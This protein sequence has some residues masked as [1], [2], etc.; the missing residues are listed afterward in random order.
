MRSRPARRL[1]LAV[2]LVAG[3]AGVFWLTLWL[4]GKGDDGAG[5]A[6]VLALPVAILGSMVAF[7]A[8]RSRPES[9]GAKVRARASTLLDQVAAAEARALQQLLGD[10]GRA[11]P[12]DIGFAHTHPDAAGVR[13]RV[14]GGPETGS[15]NTVAEFYGS[16]RLGRLLVLGEPGSGKTVLTVR[17]L[18]DL[19]EK[20]RT[21]SGERFRVPVRLSLPAFSETNARQAGVRERLDAW[22]TEQLTVVYGVPRSAAEALVADGWILPIFDGLDEMDP[23]AAEPRRAVEVITA[24]NTAAGPRRWPVVVAC[25]IANYRRMAREMPLQDATAVTMEPLEVGQIVDWLSHRFPDPTQPDGT[26]TRW[27]PVLN[28]VRA[29]PSGRLAKFLSSPLNLYLAA[30]VYRDPATGPDPRE[31]RKLSEAELD[32][33]LHDRLLAAVVEHNPSPDGTRYRAEDIRI[34]LSTLANHLAWMNVHGYS[35]TDIHLHELWRTTGDPARHGRRVRL[36]GAAIAAVLPTALSALLFLRAWFFSGNSDFRNN[37]E[38]WSIAL[39]A[40]IAFIGFVFSFAATSSTRAMERIEPR[41]LITITGLRKIFWSSITWML[42]GVLGGIPAG[43]VIGL[44]LGIDELAKMATD[45][46]VLMGAIGFAIGLTFG[47]VEANTRLRTANRPSDPQ[48]QVRRTILAQSAVA[49]LTLV[50]LGGFT[51]GIVDGLFLGLTAAL[52]L[53]L[54][55][56]PT[57]RLRHELAIRYHVRRHLLPRRPENFLDWAHTAGLLRLAGTAAQFRHREVQQR[58]TTES[59]YGATTT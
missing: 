3:T 58:L 31:L 55:G 40:L 38:R 2:I 17:L 45:T 20:A 54:L 16:L 12:A 18:L 8:L 24:L 49:G 27:R 42:L 7:A 52:G 21:A 22:V 35:G 23:G 9:D 30:N 37:L 57:P 47:A 28:L 11:E 43:L 41:L 53:F 44:L 10:T 51:V 13:W 33:F 36:L 14:D 29:H 4:L 26:Q 46:S 34:W 56:G 39:A 5:I 1:W 19:A 6:N 32:D 48:H 25:R 59:P 50:T 15:L